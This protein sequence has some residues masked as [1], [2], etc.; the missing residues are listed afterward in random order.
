MVSRF[1][2]GLKFLL[3]S[4]I[5]RLPSQTIRLSFYRRALGMRIGENTVIY[6]RAEIRHGRGIEIG[7]NSS[8]GHDV[9]LDGRCGLKIGNSVNFSSGAWIW[10]LQ[11]DLDD[12]D[13]AAKGAPVQIDDYAWIGGRVIVLPGVHIGEGAVVAS[14]AVVTKNVEPYTVV[15]GVPARKIKHRARGLRYKLGA[16]MWFV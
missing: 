16:F 5:G 4:W 8:I 2:I 3:M 6:G 14:G 12:P 1:K 15:A 7:A 10:T 11:H 13:F 9:V